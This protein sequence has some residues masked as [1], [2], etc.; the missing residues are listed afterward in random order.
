MPKTHPRTWL[1]NQ[2]SLAIHE[3]VTKAIEKHDDL[4]YI[5]LLG[6]LHELQGSWLKHALRD[7]RHPDQPDY[8]AGWE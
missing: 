5:E 3:A 2:A 6:I 1:V 4:T 7:E 8:P